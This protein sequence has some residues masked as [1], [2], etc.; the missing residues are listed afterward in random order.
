MCSYSCSLRVAQLFEK[1]NKSGLVKRLGVLEM[2]P[3]IQD[4]VI[5]DV[6]QLCYH[7]VRPFG[8]KLSDLVESIKERLNQY[9]NESR[10]IIVFG[11]YENISAKDQEQLKT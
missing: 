4:M 1:G 11:I 8:G 3:D 6:S 2:T 9:P 7:I 10:K 5:V